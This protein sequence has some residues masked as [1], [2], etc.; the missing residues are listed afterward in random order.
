MTR[1]LLISIVLL[2]ILVV[3]CLL[4][5]QKFNPSRGAH[6]FDGSIQSIKGNSLIVNGSFVADE[7]QTVNSTSTSN[8]EVLVNSNTKII[9]EVVQMP[10]SQELAKSGGKFYPDQLPKVTTTVDF[11]TLQKDS[12]NQAA[13]IFAKSNKNILG[14]SKFT[15]SEITY[16]VL[17]TQ[18]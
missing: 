3:A 9:K 18:Q 1:K 10:S 13:G 2:G 11:A 16:R 17:S 14:E 15:A 5:W 4:F 7:G 8:V 6:E 12:E